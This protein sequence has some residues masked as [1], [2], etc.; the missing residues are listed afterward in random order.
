MHEEK[1]ERMFSTNFFL[2]KS[3]RLADDV[4]IDSMFENK[5]KL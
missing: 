3:S 4:G 2:R 5:R 1:R